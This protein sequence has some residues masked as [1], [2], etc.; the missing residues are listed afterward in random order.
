MAVDAE[1]AVGERPQHDVHVGVRPQVDH[2]WGREGGGSV[3]G[4]RLGGITLPSSGF[5]QEQAA[6]T[7]THKWRGEGEA[8][9]GM[10]RRGGGAMC[11]WDQ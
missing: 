3:G 1:A 4:G 6:G 7:M 11:G 5:R 9:G 8:V 10:G 2:R